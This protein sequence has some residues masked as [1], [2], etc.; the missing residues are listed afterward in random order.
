MKKKAEIRLNKMIQRCLKVLKKIVIV[1]VTENGLKLTNKK[2]IEPKHC[3]Y[4]KNISAGGQIEP[5]SGKKIFS[6]KKKSS[7]RNL[8]Q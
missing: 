5:D 2:K 7:S 3:V 6:R 4:S 1:Y 8:H